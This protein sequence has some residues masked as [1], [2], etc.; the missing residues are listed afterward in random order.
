V[1]VR[2]SKQLIEKVS[3]VNPA[4]SPHCNCSLANSR[5]LLLAPRP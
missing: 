3:G 1:D 5:L 4:V 2:D